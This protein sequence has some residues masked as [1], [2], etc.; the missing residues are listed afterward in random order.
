MPTT[1]NS[2]GQVVITP[3]SLA[4]SFEKFRPELLMM[5]VFGLKDLLP[6]VSLRPGVRYK[7]TVGELSGDAQIRPFSYFD[8][9]DKDITIKGRT[10]ETYLGNV[11]KSF[12]PLSVVQ[13]VY[14]D[15]A[16]NPEALKNVPITKAVWTKLLGKLGEH[17]YDATFTAKRNDAGDTTADLFDGF[18]TIADKEVAA[19]N[20]ST[21][22]GNYLEL[23]AAISR[24]NAEDTVNDVFDAMDDHLKMTNT[25][26]LMSPSTYLAYCRDYQTTHG[27][28][29]YNKEFDKTF[30]EG[31]QNRCALQGLSC[32]PKDVIIV[33]PRSNLLVG[34][35]TQGPEVMFT[36]RDSKKSHFMLDFV[37][38]MFFGCQFESISKERLLYA[39]VKAAA[40]GGGTTGK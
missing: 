2:Q 12:S 8:T 33:S 16:T 35:A 10:L 29:P 34:V 3:D 15:A 7:E 36:I 22:N 1:A 27:A 23:A 38:A 4:H 37:A 9:D 40:G 30:V 11:V 26:M 20:L 6:Y 19:G 31:S 18:C 17:L 5:P 14:G 24:D 28:L 39:K 21:A 25:T 13:S 32:V